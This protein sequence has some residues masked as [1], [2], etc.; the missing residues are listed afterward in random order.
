MKLQNEIKKYNWYHAIDFGNG[1]VTSRRFY[2]NRP[3]NY[4][5]FPV[6]YFLE[7]LNIRNMDCIDV[8]TSDGIVAFILKQEGARRVVATDRAPIKET[9]LFVRDYLNLEIDHLPHSTLDNY[10]I[11]NKLMKRGLPTKY[12]LVVL[13]ALVQ[14]SYDPLVV[15]MHARKLLKLGGIMIVETVCHPGEDPALY[16][17]TECTEPWKSPDTYFL[18]TI[19]CL[20]AF[21]RYLSTRLLATIVNAERTA[22]LMQAC[23]PNE[24]E[25]KSEILDLIINKGAHYGPIKFDELMNESDKSNITYTGRGGIW[26][27]DMRAFKT[28]FSLQPR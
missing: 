6:Y 1:V 16:F 3:P 18:P 28:R 13:A 25:D 4:T 14:H 7:N 9:F 24:I 19:S 11:Y 23:K 21:S 10:D 12:D 26:S 15:M 27:L 22:I 20:Q 8:G 5:L 17:N 2:A